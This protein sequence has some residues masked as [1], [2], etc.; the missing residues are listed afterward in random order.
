MTDDPNWMVLITRDTNFICGAVERRPYEAGK[1]YEAGNLW[2]MYNLFGFGG[3][4]YQLDTLIDAIDYAWENYWRVKYHLGPKNISGDGV[5]HT[6][7]GCNEN[8]DPHYAYEK[9]IRG[10]GW[11]MPFWRKVDEYRARISQ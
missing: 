4:N 3:G 6:E 9:E 2:V 5:D 1:T 10:E 11:Y 8:G 7:H